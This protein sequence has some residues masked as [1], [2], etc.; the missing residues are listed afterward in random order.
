[1]NR[2][3]CFLNVGLLGLL[4]WLWAAAAQVPDE[5]AAPRLDY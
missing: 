3:R 2:S 1:M 4:F 5:L